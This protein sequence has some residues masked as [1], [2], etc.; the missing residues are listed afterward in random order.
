MFTKPIDAITFEDIEVFCRANPEGN[1]VEYKS[2]IDVRKHIPKTVS[3]FAN[4]LGGILLIG[5]EAD[6]TKNSVIF[7]IKGTSLTHDFV[8][9]IQQSCLDGIYPVLD[10]EV[11][12]IDV[13]DSENVVVVVRVD[14]SS[15]TPHSIDK[16]RKIYIR[17]GSMSK[18]YEFADRDQ[19]ESLF[20][21]GEK[22]QQVV[23]ET[24]RRIEERVE[25]VGFAQDRPNITVIARPLFPDSPIIS[26]ASL[27]DLDLWFNE[28]KKVPGGIYSILIDAIEYTEV[29]EY[30]IAYHRGDLRCSND[31]NIELTQYLISVTDFMEARVPTLRSL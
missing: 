25:S 29:N 15:Q 16:K 21:R 17:T 6:Q 24:L 26:T 13:P 5:I 8:T 28:P 9:Q 2:Q 30:G 3:A 23:A 14:A 19:I 4:N 22:S 11:A 18:P 27:S 20:K 10:P 31:L 12:V 7:P 1:R